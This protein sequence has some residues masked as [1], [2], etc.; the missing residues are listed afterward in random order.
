MATS[1]TSDACFLSLWK[2]LDIVGKSNNFSP[3]LVRVLLWVR[4]LVECWN[5]LLGTVQGEGPVKISS[6][7]S[8]F[9]AV[10]RT[11]DGKGCHWPW[12][13]MIISISHGC[14]WDCRNYKAYNVDL[15][16]KWRRET[17][18]AWWRLWILRPSLGGRV[19]WAHDVYNDSE[20]RQIRG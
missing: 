19:L 4:K 17:N 13:S 14:Q 7:F 3:S 9:G 1:K 20:S 11:L 15:W 18:Q 2:N 10:E 6:A 12:R 5:F 16:R 8:A